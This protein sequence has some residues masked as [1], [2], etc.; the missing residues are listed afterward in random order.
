M[1]QRHTHNQVVCL[2]GCL[3][4]FFAENKTKQ[5]K[6]KNTSKAAAVKIIAKEAS[7]TE[8][9]AAKIQQLFVS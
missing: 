8:K 4:V 6:T 7:L 2:H 3:N 1:Q 5:N 9:G